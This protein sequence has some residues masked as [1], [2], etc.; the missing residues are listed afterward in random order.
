MLLMSEREQDDSMLMMK[1][2]SRS[3]EQYTYIF[4][5]VVSLVVICYML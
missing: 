2:A 5:I 3:R 1:L 4:S